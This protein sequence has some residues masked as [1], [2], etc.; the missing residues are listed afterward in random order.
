MSTPAVLDVPRTI[1]ERSFFNPENH[2][3]DIAHIP[4]DQ[5][6]LAFPLL[7][8]SKMEQTALV[9]ADSI[10]SSSVHVH[11]TT[12]EWL[13]SMDSTLWSR[14]PVRDYRLV[15]QAD[16][17]RALLTG[18]LNHLAD[19]HPDS[20]EVIKRYV[21]IIGWMEMCP[22][23]ETKIASASCPTLPFAVFTSDLGP[24]ELPPRT[25][26]QSDCQRI[27]AENLLHEA[28]HQRI[29]FYLLE[30]DVLV[31]DYDSATATKVDIAWR[32]GLAQSQWEVDRVFHAALVYNEVLR[33]RL[34]EIQDPS[35]DP[36]ARAAFC[37]AGDAGISAV[38]FLADSLLG[39]ERYF[40]DFGF[41]LVRSLIQ[42]TDTVA[43][44]WTSMRA[45][46]QRA[47]VP[48]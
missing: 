26:T 45:D 18:A 46:Q 30:N 24:R 6:N 36:V 19:A 23:G 8:N 11:G 13:S 39:F 10:T 1:G 31:E 28:T 48:G 44:V 27:L 29:N 47:G 3:S 2:L 4:S 34:R 25:V 5:L 35:C 41:D 20:F 33:Y 12:F 38:R 32:Q 40:T 16:H 37:E 9:P 17:R 7:L 22:P 21:R 14:L 15:D 42:R 43:E